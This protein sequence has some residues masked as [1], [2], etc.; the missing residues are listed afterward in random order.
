V[1]LA[2][3]DAPAPKRL[4]AYVVSGEAR[5]ESSELRTFLGALL[6]EYMVPSVFVQ[7]E[8]FPLLPNGKIDRRA[9]PAPLS[10]V[11]A[12]KAVILPRTALEQSLATIWAAVLRRE[13]V[14]VE[15]NFF[16]IGGDSILGIQ[17]VT[18]ARQAGLRITPRQIFQH[19]T[20][21]ELALVA[22][23]TSA[24]IAEAG[25][26]TGPVPLTP[27]QRWWSAQELASPHHYNQAFLLELRERVEP[28][29]LEQAIGHLLEHH[30]AL[31]L[32]L[33]RSQGGWEQTIAPPGGAIPFR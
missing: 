33:R 1:V 6:P 9:L 2:R 18:R 11:S 24:V 14:G 4:V 27:I 30:D 8:R 26:I 22:E 10:S 12:E 20:I 25:A 7:L 19:Q 31:R 32:R 21:A 16:E 28:P 13:A 5:P 23:P 3:E 17:V 29:A 15:E